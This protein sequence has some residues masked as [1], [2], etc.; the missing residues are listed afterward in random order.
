MT[1]RDDINPSAPES[2]AKM[3]TGVSGLDYVLA[4]GLPANRLYLVQGD[5][6]VGKTTLGLQFFA[7]KH[8]T[9]LMLDDRTSDQQDNHLQSL[10]HGVV[11]LEQLSP[12]YGA[13]RRRLRVL[14]LRG[15]HFRG[16][17]HDFNITRG[18]LRVFPRLVAAD[19]PET[20]RQE[21]VKSGIPEIDQL[22]GGGL[23]RG[24]STLMTG[25]PVYGGAEH[26]LLSAK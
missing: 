1:K 2:P 6:G 5:P 11:I 20:F 14:K 10:A 18:G 26:P 23:H 12:L 15:V 8:C 25:I 7:G 21:M 13:E 22:L 17:Y 3:L 16:G 19:H 24:T 4:G 9:V